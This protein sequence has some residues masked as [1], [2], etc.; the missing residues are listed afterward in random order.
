MKPY[1]SQLLT[2]SLEYLFLCDSHRI[3]EAV[4]SNWEIRVLIQ[5]GCEL[6]GFTKPPDL[7]GPQFYI[8]RRKMLA[9]V[10]ASQP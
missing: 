3:Q 6:H 1:E 7:A 4:I 5:P 10:N 8:Y 2:G 9:Q